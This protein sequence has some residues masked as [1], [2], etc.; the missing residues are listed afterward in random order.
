VNEHNQKP[1]LLL[2]GVDGRAA[3]PFQG[4]ILCVAPPVKRT[5]PR[6]SGGDHPVLKNCSGAYRIDMNAFAAGKIGGSPDPLLRR[7]GTFVHCQWWARDPNGIAGTSTS[8][9]L[10]YV[11]GP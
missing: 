2:Y 5:P 3:L 1:G 4:G 10:Q 8:D 6:N 7:A 9:A 11:V